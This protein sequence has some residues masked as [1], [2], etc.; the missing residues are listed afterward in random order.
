MWIIALIGAIL[1]L[2]TFLK[3]RPAAIE[4]A[5]P[6]SSEIVV[7]A[8]PLVETT[9]FWLGVGAIMF[10]LLQE[11]S[12]LGQLLNGSSTTALLILAIVYA[13]SR[14]YIKQAYLERLIFTITK[15]PSSDKEA[16]RRETLV[17][18]TPGDRRR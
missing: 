8:R 11:F 4:K 7:K 9:E 10:K 3:T 2:R 1:L 17:P 18:F 6:A 13:L 15:S 14:S 12:V 16:T 5:M